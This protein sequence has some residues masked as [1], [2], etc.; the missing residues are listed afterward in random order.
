MPREEHTRKVCEKPAP[1]DRKKRPP[2]P[3]KDTPRTSTKVVTA[4]HHRQ[5]LTLA[6]WFLVFKFMDEHPDIVQSQVVEHFKTCQDGALLFT[7]ST[8]SRKLERRAELE[9]RQE[10]NPNALS[11]KRPRVVTRPDIERALVLWI[12]HMQENKE[13]VTG[14]MLREKRKRF[15]ELLNVPENEQLPGEGWVQSF[16]KAYKLKEYRLHGEASSA[17][18]SAIEAERKR[19]QD[20]LK[21]FAPQDRWNFDETSLFPK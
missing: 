13:T 18:P 1:Y 4:T 16:C 9:A 17:E 2:A 10:A 7:Q 6:D 3:R 5:N 15:E 12:A 19:M 21:K 11:S 8:L 20:L 14:P